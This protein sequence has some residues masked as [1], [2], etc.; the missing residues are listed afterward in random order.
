MVGNW[1]FMAFA[2]LFRQLGDFWKKRWVFEAKEC[3]SGRRGFSEL[4]RR[5]ARAKMFTY[6]SRSVY[7]T[8]PATICMLAGVY[9]VLA[10]ST[11]SPMIS[12]PVFGNV[13]HRPLVIAHRGGGGLAPENTLEAFRR[14]FELGADVLELD[15]RVS[16][17]G[18]FVVIHD[19]TVDRTTNGNGE[20]SK[21]PFDRLQT[22][23]AGYKFTPDGGVTFP[24]RGKGV[25]I[26]S[27]EEVLNEFPEANFN[28][29]AKNMGPER[30]DA[31]CS[32]VRQH[33]APER[34]VVAS[35]GSAFLDEFRR[36]CQGI[37]TSAAFTEVVSFI[38]RYKAGVAP[39]FSPRMQVLQVP[40]KVP[41]LELL[42][43]EFIA[44]ARERNLSVHGWTINDPRTMKRLID[45]QIDGIMTDRPDLLLS[46]VRETNH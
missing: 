29:E 14:S 38:A 30:A 7:I 45:A 25:R 32:L 23:D 40:E 11:G 16:A 41:G 24:F 15:V 1:K 26:S 46:A 35:A 34:L 31:F 44:A 28:I 17:D 36:T 5:C 39:S 33:V 18:T 21:I 4:C 13:D 6:F 19:D 9:V 43:P 8:V 3:C 12:A 2:P 42:T 37:P 22:L 27:L 10:L 20:V